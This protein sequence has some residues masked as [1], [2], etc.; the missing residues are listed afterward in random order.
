MTSEGHVFK[1]ELQ[2]SISLTWSTF[3]NILTSS[4][5]SISV[6]ADERFSRCSVNDRRNCTKKGAFSNEAH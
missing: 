6:D 3:H 1:Q 5:D 4:L 2:C